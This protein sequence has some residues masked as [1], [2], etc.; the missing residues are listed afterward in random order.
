[1]PSITSAL[2]NPI[3][4]SSLGGRH[5]WSFITIAGIES[6]GIIPTDGIK[7][8]KRETGWDKKK[9]KGT[10]GATMTLTTLPPAEG[11]IEFCLWLPVHFAQWQEFIRQLIYNPTRK[12][13]DA[14]DIGH[15]ALADLQIYSVVVE[16]I[17]PLYHQGLN[18]YAATIEFAEWLPPPKVSATSTPSGSKDNN[19]GDLPGIPP[20]P[21]ADAI[22]K[23][24]G[25]KALEHAALSGAPE[26]SAFRHFIKGE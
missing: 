6:P 13:A 8:F 9:G 18:K 23:A 10:Q 2:L 25:Q 7:G 14:F 16:S 22:Q 3:S 1:M 11:S 19:P 15:P 5:P 26:P 4:S 20:D 21:E 12:P 17:T 24:I